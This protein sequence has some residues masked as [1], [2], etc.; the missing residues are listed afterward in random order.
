MNEEIRFTNAGKIGRAKGI[1][2]GLVSDNLDD[3][4]NNKLNEII[5]ILDSIE[6]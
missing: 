4:T 1:T 2:R 5:E 3:Y 6:L